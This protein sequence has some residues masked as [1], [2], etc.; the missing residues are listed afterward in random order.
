MASQLFNKF[1]EP[2]YA[3]IQVELLYM[4]HVNGGSPMSLQ[5]SLAFAEKY[6]AT[7]T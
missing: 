7:L 2:R 6:L 5:F 1:K 4:D 3:L